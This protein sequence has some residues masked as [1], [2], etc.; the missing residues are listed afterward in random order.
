MRRKTAIL[1][2]LVTTLSPFVLSGCGVV[3]D[4]FGEDTISQDEYE[5]LNV[6]EQLLYEENECGRY[7]RR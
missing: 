7:E 6:L 2:A 3:S 4:C 1:A 5:D